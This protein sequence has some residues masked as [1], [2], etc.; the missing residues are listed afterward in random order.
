MKQLIGELS[1]TKNTPHFLLIYL[2]DS[3]R[4]GGKM[5]QKVRRI[6]NR[7]VDNMNEKQLDET[8]FFIQSLM[9]KFIPDEKV[10]KL[11]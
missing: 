10:R 6:I 3:I 9:D 4:I 2:E 8:L 7:F 11:K 5:K 1:F